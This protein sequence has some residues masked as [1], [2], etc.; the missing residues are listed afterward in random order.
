MGFYSQGLYKDL[1]AIILK[2]I[3]T[4]SNLIVFAV[5]G[6]G[7]SYF[8]QKF[9]EKHKELDISYILDIDNNASLSSYNILDIDSEKTGDFL[10]RVGD[11]LRKAGINKKFAVI[12]NTPYILREELFKQSYLAKHSHLVFFF[13]ARER[14]DTDIFA[15]EIQ[16]D[17]SKNELEAIFKLSGGIGRII[18]FLA[19]N[20]D[21]IDNSIGD[22]LKNES[23][24]RIINPTIDVVRKCDNELLKELG[25]VDDDNNFRSLLLRRY[26][27]E[28]PIEP[29]FDIKV[30]EDYSF[31]EGGILSSNRL[32]KLEKMVIDE[33]LRNGG[34]VTKER[35]ADFKWGEGSYDE[36]S[37]QAIGKTMQRLN[38]K[39]TLYKFLPIIGVGYKLS[40]K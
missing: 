20:R 34:V 25:F 18:K 27:E 4:K 9:L 7:V 23:L 19:V 2:S 10:E 38:R 31:L 16:K 21:L 40:R 17:L 37:D 32:L 36:Y 11:Y 24:V 13:R 8:I 6:L 39:L 15:L 35:V 33:A 1:E 12:I 28:N 22:L 30:N 29:I 14:K 5:P 26:F 3:K